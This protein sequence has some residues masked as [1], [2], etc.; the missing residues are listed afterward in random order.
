MIDLDQGIEKA[1]RLRL[2]LDAL[3]TT[4]E[5]SERVI[6]A[7]AGN[8]Y[9]NSEINATRLSLRNIVIESRVLQKNIFKVEC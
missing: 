4:I 7:V 5:T 3:I 9:A 6:G 1:R 2:L 8:R